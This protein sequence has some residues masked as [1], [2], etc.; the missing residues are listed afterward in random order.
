MERKCFLTAVVFM[1][2]LSP[3]CTSH[4]KYSNSL[5]KGP[6]AAGS[7][8]EVSINTKQPGRVAMVLKATL[9]THIQG[10]YPIESKHSMHGKPG[11]P[12]VANIDDERFEWKDDGHPETLPYEEKGEWN[13]EGGEGVRYQIE[14][15]LS[16]S[17]GRHRVTLKIPSEGISLTV[18]IELVRQADPYILEFKPIYNG[19]GTIEFGFLYGITHMS[20]FLNG[21]ELSACPN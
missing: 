14:K 21:V 12:F 1:I 10:Y 17:P 16:L 3:A 2:G 6:F 4:E 18:G 19:P 11:F 5:C 9:K 15:N 20:A 8:T 13:P 7:V